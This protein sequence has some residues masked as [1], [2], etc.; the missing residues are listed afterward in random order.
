[1]RQADSQIKL[2]EVQSRPAWCQTKYELPRIIMAP[3]LPRSLTLQGD[4]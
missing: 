4:E 1:M 3:L 2:T